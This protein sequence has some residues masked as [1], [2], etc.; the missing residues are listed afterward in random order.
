QYVI[1]VRDPKGGSGSIAIQEDVK[2]GDPEI[3]IRI[4]DDA[5]A[6]AYVVGVVVGPDGLAVPAQ[7]SMARA[8]DGGAPI[9]HPDPKTGAFKCGPVPPGEYYLNVRAEGYPHWQRSSMT[10]ERDRTFDLGTIRL[11]AGG[12]LVLLL[13]REGGGPIGEPWL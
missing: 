6:T 13:A 3:V 2:P 9:T 10:L 8:S 11:A 12:R 4:P 1:K 5:R 7:I